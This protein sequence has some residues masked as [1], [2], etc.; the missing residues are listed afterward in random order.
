MQ[1]QFTTATP[2][3]H[4]CEC[5]CGQPTKSARQTRT[6]RGWAAGLPLRFIHGHNQRGTRG[7]F[8]P[9]RKSITDRFWPKVN[10]DGPIPAHVPELGPC[11]VWTA[12][13]NNRGYGTLS[14]DGGP[15]VYAHRLA[16][17]LQVG[18]VPTGHD[19]LH[20]CDNPPCVRGSHL[21]TGTAKDNGIDMARK[22]RSGTAKLTAADVSEI[23]SRH[24][25]GGIGYLALAQEFGM[26]R[27]TIYDVIKRVT[28]QHVL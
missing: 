16:Y 12:G 15:A 5:G 11:W 1:L 18:T 24:A 21:F 2:T 28:W 3:V 8:G 27:R 17:E 6:E 19:V 7:V 20:H 10:K 23:R 4:L 13:C 14:G 26:A 25:L 9:R 22:G